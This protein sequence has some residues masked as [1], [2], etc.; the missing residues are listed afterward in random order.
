MRHLQQCQGDT[1]IFHVESSEVADRLLK[2][3]NFSKTQ[4]HIKHIFLKE[5]DDVWAKEIMYHNNCMNKYISKFQRD[6]HKLIA[7]DFENLEKSNHTEK[8]FNL[9]DISANG[10]VLSDVRNTL[11]KTLKCHGKAS[12]FSKYLNLTLKGIRF[13]KFTFLSVRPGVRK[14]HKMR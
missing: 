1:K 11:S 7:D 12:L 6:V 3:R 13:Y 4:I 10:H 14:S 2:A 8:A 9:L 5:I